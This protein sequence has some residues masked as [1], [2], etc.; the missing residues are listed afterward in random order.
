MYSRALYISIVYALTGHFNRNTR[1]SSHS[2]I[3][4]TGQS[5]DGC[6]IHKTMPIQAKSFRQGLILSTVIWFVIHF[7]QIEKR[8]LFIFLKSWCK[9]NDLEAIYSSVLRQLISTSEVYHA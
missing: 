5:F 2:R 6:V 9:Y 7:I 1:A 8:T 4:P 3:Y